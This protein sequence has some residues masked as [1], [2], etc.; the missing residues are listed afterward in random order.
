MSEQSKVKVPE[1]PSV[2]KEE[3]APQRDI[4]ILEPSD[5]E[6][7]TGGAILPDARGTN[8]NCGYT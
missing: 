5:L 1:K 4:E 8:N 6:G 7:V 3:D 2:K